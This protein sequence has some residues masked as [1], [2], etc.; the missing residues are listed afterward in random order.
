MNLLTFTALFAVTNKMFHQR[1]QSQLSIVSWMINLC[2]VLSIVDCHCLLS[3]D[4][5]FEFFLLF[6]KSEI[7]DSVCEF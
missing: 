5:Q 2:F 7:T 1:S 6:V 4:L 3:A